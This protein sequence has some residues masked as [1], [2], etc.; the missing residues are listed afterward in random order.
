[1]EL[2]RPCLLLERIKCEDSL[3]K[4]ENIK[5]LSTSLHHFFIA[6]D[7]KLEEARFSIV[8][9]LL[10]T[11]DKFVSHV[12]SLVS[13]LNSR[14]GDLTFRKLSMKHDSSLFKSQIGPLLKGFLC[15]KV[16]NMLVFEL[17]S[18][19]SNNRVSKLQLL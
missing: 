7:Q 18:T 17:P 16:L 5:P 10:H 12:I 8:Y 6:I 13:P 11:A 14:C 9:M 2:T 19:M 15:S 3:I 1:M 4:A